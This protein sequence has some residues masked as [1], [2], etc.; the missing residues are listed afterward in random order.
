MGGKTV[1]F[2]DWVLVSV[3]LSHLHK[4]FSHCMRQ[5]IQRGLGFGDFLPSK[6][7]SC[8]NGILLTVYAFVLENS[9]DLFQNRCIS[10]PPGQTWTE[11]SKVLT[12]SGEAP[13]GRPHRTVGPLTLLWALG[14]VSLSN[15]CRLSSRN[16]PKL[17][18][19]C[20][21]RLVVPAASTSG[22]I[23]FILCVYTSLQFWGWQFVF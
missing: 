6:S 16:L 3:G 5:D 11:F 1:R 13:G 2:Y 18:V 22:R 14:G 12:V 7:E 15:Q 8:S 10:L 9:L 23:I 21:Y 17:P 19:Q 20:S 4:C